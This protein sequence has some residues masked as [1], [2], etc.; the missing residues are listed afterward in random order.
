MRT[1][2]NEP[3]AVGAEHRRIAAILVAA[4]ALPTA[5]ILIGA[6]GHAEFG[7]LVIAVVF[8]ALWLAGWLRNRRTREGSDERALDMHRRA[9]SFAVIAGGAALVAVTIWQAWVYGNRA[10]EPYLTA[11]VILMGLYSLALL[12]RRWRG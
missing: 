6:M 11:S 2:Q 10:A 12:W 1:A 7:Y 5:L 3:G 9:A 4:V 8:P